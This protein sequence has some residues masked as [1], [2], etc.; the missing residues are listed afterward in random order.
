MSDTT[1]SARWACLSKSQSDHLRARRDHSISPRNADELSVFRV[2]GQFNIRYIIGPW[3]K[4]FA[5]PEGPRMFVMLSCPFVSLHGT[6]RLK[7]QD[8]A[9][10]GRSCSTI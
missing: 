4:G 6:R 8:S 3:R 10:F 7:V 9:P 2:F 1:S 5:I